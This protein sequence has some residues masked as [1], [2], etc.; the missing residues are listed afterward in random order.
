LAGIDFQR[1]R[2]ALD[3]I[4]AGK[5]KLTKSFLVVKK[6]SKTIEKIPGLGALIEKIQD[7]ISG[8]PLY[9]SFLNLA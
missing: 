3:E 1:F 6:I 2:Y 7:G 9:H 8:G 4:E 5:R